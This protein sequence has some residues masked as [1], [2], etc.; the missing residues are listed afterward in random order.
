ML[1]RVA[2]VA[3][4]VL[5]VASCTSAS[6]PSGTAGTVEATPTDAA[7][8]VSSSS[9][10]SATPSP[11]TLPLA[12]A[13]PSPARTPRLDG[14]VTSFKLVSPG[15]G[16]AETDHGLLVTHDDG[17]SWV[18]ASPNGDLGTLAMDAIDGQT[19]FVA[20]EETDGSATTISIWHT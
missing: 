18:D 9:V 12:T 19:A 20:S 6:P 10:A 14:V 7:S 3:I 1:R 13:M 17:S 2:S 15:T 4:V 5:F 11:S 8:P 16:W